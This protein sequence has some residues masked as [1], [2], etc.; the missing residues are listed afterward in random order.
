MKNSRIT[1]NFSLFLSFNLIDPVHAWQPR[2]AK[3]EVLTGQN[4]CPASQDRPDRKPRV[5]WAKSI[6]RFEDEEVSMSQPEDVQKV[7]DATARWVIETL[8]QLEHKAQIVDPEHPHGFE[9]ILS[10]VDEAINT[11]LDRGV[12]SS[13]SK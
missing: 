10:T 6:V 12:W 7:L 9:D 3:K 1:R 8:K 2:H 11:R 4:I 13:N 5:S